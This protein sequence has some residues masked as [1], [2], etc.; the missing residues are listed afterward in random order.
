[1]LDNITLIL[2]ITLMY[3]APMIFAGLGS[4]ISEKSGVINIGIEGMM[5]FGAFAGAAA[6][7]FTGS[8]WLGFICAS[9]AGGLLA[10][11]HAL[12]TVIFKSDQTISGIAINLIGPGLSLFICRLLFAGSTS[13]GPVTNKTPKIFDGLHL[14][15][16]LKN[17][18]VD[19]TVIIALIAT[20]IMWIL[21]YKTKWGLHIQAVGEHPAAADTLGIRVN[22]VRF[23]CVSV[24]GLLAGLGGASVTLGIISRFLPT[25]IS[26]QG[27]IAIAAVIFGKWTPLGTYGACLLFG[28]AQALTVILGGGNSIIPS[29]AL[30]MFPYILTI[31]VLMLF[32]GQSVAPKASGKPYEK[33]AR[34]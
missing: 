21:I 34:S 18:N 3:S 5:T 24:S 6:C 27:Y 4:L 2:G 12:A 23:V 28:F 22:L 25:A 32:V 19:V 30:A 13:T 29:Q 31:L 20:A 14:T 10:V 33:G 15:G 8:V 17:L 26:G 9:I 11:L 7:Y 16:A 1:M